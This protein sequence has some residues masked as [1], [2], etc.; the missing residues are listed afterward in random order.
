MELPDKAEQSALSVEDEEAV[1]QMPKIKKAK[2]EG[3]R[4]PHKIKKDRK[5]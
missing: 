4:T 1:V 5:R 2:S 3:F